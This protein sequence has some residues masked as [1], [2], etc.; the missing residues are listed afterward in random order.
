MRT[1]S[2]PSQLPVW[3]RTVLGPPSCERGVER[4]ALAVG[5]P[6]G[7]G[8]G[9]LADVL[10][11][12]VADAEAEQLH[13]LAGVVLV[14]LALDVA[15]GVEPDQHGRVAA[16]RLQQRAELAQG[17]LAQQAVLAEHQGGV[18]TLAM[19]VAKWLCQNSVSFS[20]SGWP[21]WSMQ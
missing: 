16:D 19:L 17:V 15:V 9:G 21:P 20:R 4:E 3:P 7:E 18:R 14:R 10:L 8:A 1:T 5:V 6:A 11:G 13:Q 12:V 2:P